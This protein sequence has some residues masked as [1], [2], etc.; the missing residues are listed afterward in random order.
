MR[1]GPGAAAVVRPSVHR[2]RGVKI[3]TRTARRLRAI[4][5]HIMY[6]YIMMDRTR[7]YDYYYR[8]SF[9]FFFFFYHRSLCSENGCDNESDESAYTV[10][11]TLHY[12]YY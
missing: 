11:E 2:R 7:I 9:L 3:R 6:I 1:Q 5:N 8:L 12:Y 4:T 10:Q